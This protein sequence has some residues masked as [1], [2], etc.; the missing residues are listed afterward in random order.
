MRAMQS[1][2]FILLFMVVVTYVFAIVLGCP[3][4]TSDQPVLGFRL[5]SSIEIVEIARVYFFGKLM[6]V[7]K[8]SL[9]LKPGIWRELHTHTL[10]IFHSN[11]ESEYFEGSD[12]IP[13]FH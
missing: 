4:G 8:A 13:G 9:G 2:V 3:E 10:A 5:P 1:V 12:H 11:L 6:E 7:D